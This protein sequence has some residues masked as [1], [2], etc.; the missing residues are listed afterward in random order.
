MLDNKHEENVRRSIEDVLGQTAK[1]RKTKKQ[2]EDKKKVLFTAIMESICI[3]DFK[4]LQMEMLG[5]DMMNFN[6]HYQEAIDNLIELH[7]NSKQANL[8]Y[9][10]LYDRVNPDG[11]T[12]QFIDEYNDIIPLDT[13]DDLYEFI[14]NIK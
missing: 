2:P 11:T 4:S 1:L 3:A 9:W 12:E 7:F 10:F 8:I 5:V 6:I 13:P 14:K